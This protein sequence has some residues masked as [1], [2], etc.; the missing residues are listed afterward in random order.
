LAGDPKYKGK[1][2][3]LLCNMGSLDDADAYKEKQ[4]LVGNAMHVHGKPPSA[5]G[6]KY[7]PHKV[8]IDKDGF[9]VKNFDLKLPGDLDLLLSD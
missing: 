3:F 2:T 8:L 5:Y 7:I 6:I 9:V 4:G 1:V